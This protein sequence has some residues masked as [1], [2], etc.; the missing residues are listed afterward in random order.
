MME[1]QD[2][3]LCMDWDDGILEDG[4]E[5]VLLPEGD[6]NFVVTNFERGRFPGGAKIPAC[7]KAVITVEVHGEKGDATIRFDLLLYR[8]LEW[9]LSSFFRCIG[10][11]KH[12]EPLKMDWSKVVGSMGRAHVTQR[13]YKNQYG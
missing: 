12:G 13:T 6:Y 1:T 8:T 11:K 4:K 2:K 3:N 10:Q 7:N 9:R 5:F